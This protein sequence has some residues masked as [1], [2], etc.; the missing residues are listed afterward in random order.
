MPIDPKEAAEI[1]DACSKALKGAS[2]ELHGAVLA[3]LLSMWLA[4]HRVVNDLEATYK[5][6][7]KLLDEHI[8]AVVQL[9]RP[10]DEILNERYK[11][12]QERTK[13][14]PN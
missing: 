13:D 1:L 10:N 14:K 2:S 7:E 4:A 5:L 9:L 3:D 8:K 6:R 12:Q 11:A